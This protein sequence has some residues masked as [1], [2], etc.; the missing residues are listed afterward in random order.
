ME[1]HELRPRWGTFS[2]ID[3]KNVG[4]LVPEIL[5]YDRLVFPVPADDDER[6]TDKDWQPELMRRRVDELSED[7]LAHA[8]TWTKTL[9]DDWAEGMKELG[10]VGNE[11]KGLGYDMTPAVLA[12]TNRLWEDRVPPPI[13]VAARPARG[14]GWLL[15]FALACMMGYARCCTVSP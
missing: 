7:G 15:E 2:V 8:V 9:Q 4:Q 14:Q 6:W 1:L 12:M 3:H 5:L 13:P 11:I 10:A